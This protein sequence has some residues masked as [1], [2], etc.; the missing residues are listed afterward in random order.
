M[1]GKTVRVQVVVQDWG[2]TLTMNAN[3]RLKLI[4]I[5]CFALGR[6]NDSLTIPEH[7]VAT[8]TLDALGVSSVKP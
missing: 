7:E 8:Q 6:R 5:I 4:Q 1:E 2:H 3:E